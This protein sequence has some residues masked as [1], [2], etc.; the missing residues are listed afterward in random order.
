MW[1]DTYTSLQAHLASPC[2]LLRMLLARSVLEGASLLETKLTACE[3]VATETSAEDHTR[4]KCTKYK[5]NS[6]PLEM[7]NVLRPRPSQHK[8]TT[9]QHTSTATRLLWSSI[10]LLRLEQYVA[11]VTTVLNPGFPSAMN[12]QRGPHLGG[13]APRP[14]RGVGCSAAAGLLAALLFFCLLSSFYFFVL[15][16]HQP[17]E[18]VAPPC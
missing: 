14:T 13:S 5:T 8:H 18:G 12:K 7:Q 9:E 17:D 16:L 11:E 15:L 10:L 2:L 4:L 6:G 3:T 1:L